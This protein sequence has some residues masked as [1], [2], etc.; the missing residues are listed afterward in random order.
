[1]I[2]FK[3]YIRHLL[4]NKLYTAVTVVGFAISITFVLLL[5]VYIEN[6]LSVDDFH[7]HKARIFRLE[8]E[9]V[10]FSPPIAEDLKTTIP[11]IEDYTRVLDDSG[12]ISVADGEK[13]KFDYIGVDAP[14]FQIFSFPLLEGN[15]EEAL[16]TQNSIVLSKSMAL[17][18]FGSTEV[19]HRKVSINSQHKFIVSGIMEDFPENTHFKK[20]DALVNFKAFRTLWGFESILEEY[21]FCSVSIYFLARPFTDLPS[22][23][24]E[25][26][27]K[28]KKDFWLYQEG[29]ANIL[30]FTPLKELY[31]SPKDGNGTQSNSKTLIMV[32]SVIVLLIL[33]LAIGNYVSLTIAQS[34]FRGREVAIKKLLGSSK[35]KLFIQFISESILLCLLA[36]LLALFLAKMAEP[37][38]DSLLDTRLNLRDQLNLGNLLL[39]SGVFCLIGLLSGLLPAMQITSFSPIEVVKG[40]FRRKSKKV[41]SKA[42]ILFQ[43]TVTITLLACSW[44]IAKQTIFLREYDLGFAKDNIVQLEYLAALDKKASIKDALIQ[45]PG[46]K[47]VS[48]TWHSPLSGGSNQTFEYNGKPLSFQEFVVDSSFFKVF[49]IEVNPTT[50]AYTK[51]GVYLNATAL[52]SLEL[53]G[54]PLS[55]KMEEYE[56]P[57][58]GTVADFNFEK[59]NKGIRP[60]MIRQE[61]DGMYPTDIFLKISG[62]N[63]MQTLDKVESTYAQFLSNTPFEFRFIDD[64]ISQWYLKEERT[65][66]IIG[67]FTLLSFIISVMGI[68]AMSTFYIQQRNKE[69]GIRKV[70]GASIRQILSLLNLD[71]VKWVGIAFLIAVPISW[72][73][74]SKWLEGFAYKTTMNWWIFVLAGISALIIALIT[75]SWHSFKAATTNPVK[76]LRDE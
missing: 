2:F 64:T 71:F 38:Y 47:N 24:P 28:F 18:L 6:E 39:F 26:L 37:I 34:T 72:F 45:I 42:F 52:K 33:L 7:E 21:G 25:I 74:I 49:D 32:L 50:V 27:E 23:A 73:A 10:D 59:L 19:L 4:K 13:I 22:K 41:Y 53:D 62:G 31:F 5:S 57:I 54:P 3:T 12:R 43:Y 51:A 76:V 16:Q 1:M 35:K 56:V 55:Y 60:L 36:V 15:P 67:Y 46:V 14:F 48:L 61:Y 70:N 63:M 20:Q 30:E 66:K 58:L 44:L 9:T 17:Q 75:V 29:W 65:G 69:I 8:N 68:L 40:M 11:E